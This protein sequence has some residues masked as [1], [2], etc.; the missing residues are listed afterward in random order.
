MGGRD[1]TP[2]S[3][4]RFVNVVVIAVGVVAS[5]CVVSVVSVVKVVLN[6]LKSRLVVVYVML[7]RRL[8]KR[9]YVVISL[10]HCVVMSVKFQVI[11]LSLNVRLFFFVLKYLSNYFLISLKLS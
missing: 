4:T 11:G 5:H 3:T 1:R 8:V 10:C 6:V 9:R 7:L 2:S